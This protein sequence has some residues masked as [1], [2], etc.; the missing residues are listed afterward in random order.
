M[1]KKRARNLTTELAEIFTDNT[2]IFVFS[3][4]SVYNSVF[5]A[6]D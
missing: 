2:E 6:V 4:P 5:S 3:V 1:V